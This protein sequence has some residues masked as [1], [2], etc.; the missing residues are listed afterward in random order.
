MYKETEIGL[1]P[2][3]WKVKTLKNLLKGKGYIRGPFGSALRRN[4]L[5]SEGIPVYEQQHAIYNHRNFRYFIDDAK[6]KELSRFTVKDRDLIISC[7]GNVG[8][9]SL[10]K[11]EDPKGIISQALLILRPNYDNILPEYL[12]YFFTSKKGQES[13]ISRSG[14]SVQ[15]NLAKKQIIQEINIP[16]PPIKEQKQIIEILSALDDKIESNHQINQNLEEIWKA[17]FRHWFVHFEFP[18]DNA[19]PYKSSGGEM[20]DSELGEIPKG[21]E[22]RKLK[23]C[24][25]IIIDH[26]GK[27]PTKLGSDWS[28]SGIR[29]LS[30][31]NVKNG[32]IVNEESIKFVNE[33]LYSKWMK[34]EIERED[35][36]LTSEAP[37]GEFVSWDYDEKIVLSQRLFGI[38]ANK[39]VI[40]PKYLYCFMNSGLFNYELKSRATGSTVQGIRQAELM[41]TNILVP[42]LK[43]T[44][45][46][47]NLIIPLFNKITINE[48]ESKNLTKIRDSLLPKL[49]SGKIRV[50]IPEEATA[51]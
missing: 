2:E 50:N 7:S 6:F 47:Q 31:K 20:V 10:I 24:V 46:F 51:K 33:E 16:T 26:R 15:V 4:E 8:K 38:R 45:Q 9:I 11:K 43:I 44:R 30:A 40:C 18:D 22:V 27:T 17:T 28:S 48:E 25:E 42:S 1:I 14:G 32:K 19:Q 21:W 34:E 39:Q 5:Q 12:R 49:M 35:I 29:A 23:D 41:K 36:L 37:L 3:D 13:L